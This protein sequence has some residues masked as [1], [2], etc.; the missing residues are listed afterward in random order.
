MLQSLLSIPCEY[1]IMTPFFAILTSQ[2]LCCLRTSNVLARNNFIDAC[3]A[4]QFPYSAFILVRIYTFILSTTL[5]DIHVA[6]ISSF[7]RME[8]HSMPSRLLSYELLSTTRFELVCTTTAHRGMRWAVVVL[9][10]SVR[11]PALGSGG[12]VHTSILRGF[13]C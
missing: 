1:P 2:F 3:P 7:L 6:H 9:D 12:C 5:R 10:Y 11:W 13:L 4:A 8:C